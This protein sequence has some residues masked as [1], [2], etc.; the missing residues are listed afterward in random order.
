MLG[1]RVMNDC[2]RY[3]GLPMTC[4]KSKVNMFKEIQEEFKLQHQ[5]TAALTQLVLDTPKSRS[6]H[7]REEA[8]NKKVRE[9]PEKICA[10]YKSPCESSN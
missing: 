4:G 6:R 3:L 9:S 10:I 2:E 5:Q 1:A 7:Y 8:R